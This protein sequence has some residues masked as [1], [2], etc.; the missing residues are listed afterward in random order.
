MLEYET[1]DDLREQACR[2]LGLTAASAASHIFNDEGVIIADVRLLAHSTICYVAPE[3]VVN[4]KRGSHTE[5]AARASVQEFRAKLQDLL[6]TFLGSVPPSD[7]RNTVESFMRKA[8]EL[9]DDRFG[10]AALPQEVVFQALNAP[11][12]PFDEAA[13]GTL[14]EMAVALEQYDAVSSACLAPSSPHTDARRPQSMRWARNLPGIAD[15]RQRAGVASAN[16]G[17]Q[18]QR[19]D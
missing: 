16:D 11:D 6:N 9:M 2:H 8:L 13:N 4:F 5:D 3:N 19:V 14:A 7:C 18:R 17:A 15:L 1:L 10:L 12:C